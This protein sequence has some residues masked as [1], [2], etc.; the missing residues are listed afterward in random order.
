M[1]GGSSRKGRRRVSR[2]CLG[3]SKATGGTLGLTHALVSLSSREADAV[4]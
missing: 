4:E 3:V 2:P 1:S